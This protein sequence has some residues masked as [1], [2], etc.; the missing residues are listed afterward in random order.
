[1]K[2]PGY[3]WLASGFRNPGLSYPFRLQAR[4]R[5]YHHRVL[6]CCVH[7]NENV[8]SLFAPTSQYSWPLPGPGLDL[9]KPSSEITGFK[10][11]HW[12]RGNALKKYS[13]LTMA[14]L[15]QILVWTLGRRGAIALRWG[16]AFSQKV[17][18]VS[19]ILL[20]HDSAT[21]PGNYSP[22]PFSSWNPLKRHWK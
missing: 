3:Y 21:T 22:R 5:L 13:I 18:S 1:M 15:L 16:A 17:S 19:H 12:Q 9:W 2:F 10:H 20:G 6:P 7:L 11:V 8:W 14:L 4:S